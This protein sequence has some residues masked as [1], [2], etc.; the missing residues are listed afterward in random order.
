VKAVLCAYCLA[1]LERSRCVCG[2]ISPAQRSHLLDVVTVAREALRAGDTEMG[3][4]LE[5]A[6]RTLRESPS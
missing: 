6:A 3:A 5:Q 1:N 2:Q 4:A